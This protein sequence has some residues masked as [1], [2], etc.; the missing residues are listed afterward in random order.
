MK[1][2][3]IAD[4]SRTARMVARRCLEIAGLRGSVFLEAPDG[5]AAF[6][7]AKRSRPDLI[8]ADLNMPLVAGDELLR[9]LK[10]D[11][12]LKGIPVVIVTSAASEARSQELRDLG[13]ACVLPKPV[14]PASLKQALDA[15]AA[16]AGKGR[17]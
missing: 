9:S 11:P 16:A 6:S 17:A 13:A 4:D 7:S 10:G 5:S 15:L 14:S 12:D 1:Q 3:L 8:V 2:I